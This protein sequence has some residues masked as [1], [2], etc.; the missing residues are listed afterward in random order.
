MQIAA[1]LSRECAR[2]IVS[3]ADNLIAI[4][5]W[6]CRRATARPIVSVLPF[7]PRVS[8]LQNLLSFRGMFFAEESPRLFPRR[9]SGLRSGSNSPACVSLMSALS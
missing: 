4:K 2:A 1:A 8:C 6:Y 7:F 5:R 3:P 9:D